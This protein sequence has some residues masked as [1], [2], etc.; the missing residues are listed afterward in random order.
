MP[1]R[2]ISQLPRDAGD[3]TS[4]G[5]T[6]ALQVSLRKRQLLKAGLAEQ[7]R[8]VI[9]HVL[10]LTPA[11]TDQLSKLSEEE[12]K[13]L[14][15]PVLEAL[16]RSDASRFK[17]KLVP[18]PAATEARTQQQGGQQP[19]QPPQPPRRRCRVKIEVEIEA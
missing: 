17:V 7:P 4:E 12:V 6:R 9:Q 19:P 2:D 3:F 11:Q 18:L 14:A 16:E 8:E 15:A 5:L 1:A 13:E 10:S